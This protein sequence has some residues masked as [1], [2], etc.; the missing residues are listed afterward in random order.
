MRGSMDE[1]RPGIWRLRVYTGKDPVTGR[2]LHASRTFMGTRR[3]AE[4]ALSRFVTDVSKGASGQ[5]STMT[6]AGLLDAFCD[7]SE[8]VGRSPTTVAEYRRLSLNL[9]HGIGH[10]QLAKLRPAHLDELYAVLGSRGVPGGRGGLSPA[11]VNRYHDLL[12][13]ACRQAVKW[14]WLDASPVDRAT[15]PSEPRAKVSAPTPTELHCLIARAAATKPSN[16]LLIALAAITGARRGELCA[17]RWSDLDLDEGVVHIRRAVKQVGRTLTIGDTKTHAERAVALAPDAVEMLRRF[18]LQLDK[19]ATEIEIPLAR[20]PFV[21]SP[22]VDHGRPYP[23]HTV[24][25]MFSRISAKCG[26][27]FHLHQLRHFAATQA[28]AAGFDPVAVAARLGH[29]DASVTL[30]VYGH[31]IEDRD[32][33][34]ADTLG[35]IVSPAQLERGEVNDDLEAALN[36]YADDPCAQCGKPL[37]A[38]WREMYNAETDQLEKVHHGCS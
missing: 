26:T 33:Q 35:G 25:V 12:K 28:I 7:H 10:T 36:A 21:F 34:I 15:A 6:V 2:K 1:R 14:G 29:A 27:S 31:A 9:R 32:R 3:Q 16:G 13:S 18:R 22:A 17:L 37:G 5:P 8:N 11:S 24:S 19:L 30:R 38:A 4:T 23:P 20:D